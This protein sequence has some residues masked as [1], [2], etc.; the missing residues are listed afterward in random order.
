MEGLRESEEKYR[1][2]YEHSLEGIYQISFEG[3]MVS[4]NPAM[5]H[6]GL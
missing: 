6:A 3:K 5:A 1:A 2:I 4:A